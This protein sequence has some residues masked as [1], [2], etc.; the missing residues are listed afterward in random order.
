MQNEGHV[1]A[2]EFREVGESPS[3]LIITVRFHLRHVFYFF[4]IHRIIEY[5]IKVLYI[6]NFKLLYYKSEY[7]LNFKVN[8]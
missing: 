5:D 7:T 1:H 8:L 2:L 4:D 3:V 6:H